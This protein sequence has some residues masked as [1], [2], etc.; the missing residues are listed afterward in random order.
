MG[1]RQCYHGHIGTY[2][3]GARGVESDGGVRVDNLVSRAISPAHSGGH[4]LGIGPRAG[5]QTRLF[6]HFGRKYHFAHL[7]EP[8]HARASGG[9]VT[10]L[11]IEK[12]AFKI[13]RHLNIHRWRCCR[14]HAK[15]G[16]VTLC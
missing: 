8:F 10:A 7:F 12:K 16:I 9:A 6:A 3:S 13:A 1:G 15:H 2:A 11:Q 14:S 4:L 5:E